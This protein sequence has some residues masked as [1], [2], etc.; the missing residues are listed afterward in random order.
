MNCKSIELI[1]QAMDEKGIV[2][3]AR[4]MDIGP[5]LIAGFHI[6]NGSGVQVQF[7]PGDSGND[8][9]VRL[10]GMIKSVSDDKRSEILEVVNACNAKYRHTRFVLDEDND[11]NIE[12]DFPSEIDDSSI[13]KAACEI[14]IRIAKIADASYPLFMKVLWG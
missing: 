2:Y 13:G 5:Y 14:F 9:S 1:K 6:K 10:Y 4:E 11:V 8:V 12:Y 3:A 7:D